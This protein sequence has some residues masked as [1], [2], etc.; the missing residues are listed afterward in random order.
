MFYLNFVKSHVLI[1]SG[2]AFHCLAEKYE[3]QLRPKLVDKI[4]LHCKPF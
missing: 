3:K 1:Q 4:A 2:N